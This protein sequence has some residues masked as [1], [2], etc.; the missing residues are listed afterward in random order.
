MLAEM[1]EQSR[2][3]T[4]LK[5]LKQAQSMLKLASKRRLQQSWQ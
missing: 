5:T 3:E 4:Q 2:K 1:D